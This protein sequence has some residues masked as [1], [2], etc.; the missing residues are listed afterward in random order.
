MLAIG[1]NVTRIAARVVRATKYW[2]ERGYVSPIAARA[3]SAT[4][5]AAALPLPYLAGS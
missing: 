3:A 4:K 2:F 1:T 5:P